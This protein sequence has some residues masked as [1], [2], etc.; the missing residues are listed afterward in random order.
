MLPNLAGAVADLGAGW[1]F[2][3]AAILRS[4]KVKHLH[5]VEAEHAGV[6]CLS[7]NLSD[8]RVTLHWADAVQ[9]LPPG[10]LDAVVMNPPFHS[11]RRPDPSIGRAFIAAAGRMLGVRGS[12]WMVANRHLP[13]EDVLQHAFARVEEIEGDSGFKF[14]HATAPKSH[15]R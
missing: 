11:G 5:A 6:A 8:P 3:S 2:L 4:A 14:I 1:G 10:P 9:W 12:L 7:A 15:M 13:Y